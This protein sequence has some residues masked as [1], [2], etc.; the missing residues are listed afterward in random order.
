MRVC[1]QM[2]VPVVPRGAG[3]SLAGGALPTA[4]SI[5]LGTMRLRDVLEID[6]DNRFIR[7]QT[8]ITN[9]AV[10]AE[11]EPHGFFYAPDPPRSWPAPSRAISR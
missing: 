10:S 4:D 11:L 7:V 1:H 9:L 5:I 8:G 3:T 6:P 2:G